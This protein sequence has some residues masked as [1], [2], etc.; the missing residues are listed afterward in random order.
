M[1]YWYGPE[2]K[3]LFVDFDGNKQIDNGYELLNVNTFENALE[4]LYLYPDLC[5][6]SDCYVWTDQNSNI[7]VDDREL[8]EITQKF[9]ILEMV[10]Y[11]EGK[12]SHDVY[13]SD[14]RDR[15]YFVYGEAEDKNLGVMYAT[16]PTYWMKGI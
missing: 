10:A 1:C 13:L 4:L 6:Y 9:N 5:V 3:I 15:E 7:R 2:T 12:L 16:K 11:P 8:E 14:D